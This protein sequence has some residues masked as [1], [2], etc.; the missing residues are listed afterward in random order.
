V[1]TYR[2]EGDWFPIH[3]GEPNPEKP[4]DIH[5]AW[6]RFELPEL[7][8]TR[9]AIHLS[10]LTARDVVIY[11]DNEVVYE[12]RR[13]YPFTKNEILLPLEQSESNKF[14]Y[15]SLETDRD[16][17]GL[18][19]LIK[20]GEYEQ[21]KQGYMKRDILDVILGASLIFISLAM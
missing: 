6:I 18:K 2:E 15:I 10:K 16:W 19:E 5:S 20:V 3:Y 4:I 21:L 14:M 13:N 12:S 8:W 1:F 11:I 17:L 7:T 9:P